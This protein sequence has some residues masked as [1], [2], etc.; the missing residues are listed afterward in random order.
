MSQKIAQ[1]PPESK[2]EWSVR[3]LAPIYKQAS[4]L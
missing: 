1:P 2:K 3:Y 4:K